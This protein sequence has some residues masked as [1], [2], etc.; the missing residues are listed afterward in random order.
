MAQGEER[1]GAISSRV[2]LCKPYSVRHRGSNSNFSQ[3]MTIT[4]VFFASSGA[5]ALSTPR[6]YSK[7]SELLMSAKKRDTSSI[8]VAG[9]SEIDRPL[10]RWRSSTD[11][12][13]EVGERVELA[14]K[15]LEDILGG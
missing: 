9:V 11:V 6:L 2:K 8:G 5:P 15:L 1:R 4:I 7:I 13:V 10:I 14:E 3:S 12:E